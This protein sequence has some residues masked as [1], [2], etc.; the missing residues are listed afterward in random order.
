[1]SDLPMDLVPDQENAQ[2]RVQNRPVNHTENINRQLDRIAY[3]RSMN[4]PWA[5][6]LYQLRDMLVGFE[7][8]EFYDGV[9]E[10]RRDGI[11]ELPREAQER[12]LAAFAARGWTTYPVR[13][14]MGPHGPVFR[15]TAQDLSKGLRIIMRLL[16]RQKLLKKTRRASRL[17]RQ[18]VLGPSSPDD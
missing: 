18:E 8:A 11:K 16:D 10:D 4:Q 5:E 2:D 13:A 17:D 7:D 12:A 6:A 1:M 15:P 14:F 3:L 9:P